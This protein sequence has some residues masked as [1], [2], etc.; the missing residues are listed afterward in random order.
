VYVQTVAPEDATGAVRD[1]YASDLADR[2][3]VATDTLL[4]SLRPAVHAAWREL[5][6]AIRTTLRLREYELVTIAAARAL[7]CR[8]CVSAHGAVAV[9]N[10][11]VATD[12][13]EAIV[14]DFRTAGLGPLE[15]A[16][17]DL[18][19]KVAVDAHRVTPADVDGLRAFGLRDEEILDVVLAAAARSFYS[20]ALEALGVPPSP[21]LAETNGLLDGAGSPVSWKDPAVSSGCA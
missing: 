5:I 12:Q 2:G 10:R 15:V 21:E 13:L 8:A 19:D 1:M 6:R 4:F 16:L 7:G 9:R 11:I 20:K 14:R 18:A 3:Y 17:M